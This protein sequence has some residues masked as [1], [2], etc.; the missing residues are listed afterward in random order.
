MNRL[1]R[2][3]GMTLALLELVTIGLAT[4]GIF[5]LLIDG[6]KAYEAYASQFWPTTRGEII[7]STSVA[8]CAS[9]RPVTPFTPLRS[10]PPTILR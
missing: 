6:S 1:K 7:R 9:I 4:A 5:M 3:S 10:T 2:M 8:I